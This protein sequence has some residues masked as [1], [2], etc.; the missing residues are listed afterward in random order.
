MTASF[1]P[2]P[3]QPEPNVLN[4]K[5]VSSSPIPRFDFDSI[6]PSS[7]IGR[8]TTSLKSVKKNAQVLGAAIKSYLEISA[9]KAPTAQ[10]FLQHRLQEKDHDF[11][12]SEAYTEAMTGAAWDAFMNQPGA[13]AIRQQ[14]AM[15]MSMRERFYAQYEGKYVA[16]SDGQILDSDVDDSVLLVRTREIRRQKY[17]LVIRVQRKYRPA[18]L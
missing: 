12:I 18:E 9:P 3:R 14:Q 11:E 4:F 1:K 13:V 10:L 5:R 8:Q 6:K 15:F 17:V 2:G 7:P 16:F